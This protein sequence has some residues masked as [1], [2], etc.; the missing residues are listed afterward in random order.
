[1]K[2]KNNR[3]FIAMSV[4]YSIF[5]VF[6]M[7]MI[8]IMLSYVSSRRNSN[9]IK[10]DIRN[11]FSA[12]GP[13]VSFSQNGSEDNHISYKV[14]VD[15]TKGRY[16]LHSI[17]YMWSKT[18]DSV[19]SFTNVSVGADNKEEKS[20]FAESPQADDEENGTDYY[21]I[22]KACD[23]NLNCTIVISKKFHTASSDL[24]TAKLD[25]GTNVNNR[26]RTLSG[27][28][29]G[30]NTTITRILRYRNGVPSA[31]NMTSSHVISAADS[32]YPVYAWFNSSGYLYWYS[33]AD[34][35]QLN[36]DSSNLFAYLTELTNLELTYF[37]TD[38][39]VDFSF[40]FY[41]DFKLPS[42]D[43]SKFN[44]SS[45]TN[46]SYMFSNMYELTTLN[47]NSFNT[48][49]VTDMN[50]MFDS[51]SNLSSWTRTKSDFKTNKVTNMSYMFFNDDALTML[52]FDSFDTRNVTNMA[53][54]LED[55]NNLVT[56]KVGDYFITSQVTNSANMFRNCAKLK[57][58]NGTSYNSSKVDKTYARR[59]TSTTP[60][61]FTY[62]Q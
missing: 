19:G 56:I 41:C 51:C 53:S 8:T 52:E 55:M 5:V 45:A 11:Q 50:H 2:N 9:R 22:V 26:I 1:M 23:V 59:D 62:Y 24:P 39:V 21:L 54:M 61:Y 47:T 29:T 10:T 14:S 33:E 32:E 17:G 48:S 37:R 28:A 15:V 38:N 27:Q 44:T 18:M 6:I 34:V 25:T 60:G 7:I 46:M 20:F 40:F 16:E 13:S 30:N 12:A 35:V 4:I 42:V 57:G 43:L 36:P 3:G 31:S 49:N 58:E